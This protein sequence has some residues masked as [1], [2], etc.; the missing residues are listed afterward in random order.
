MPSID[1]VV[2]NIVCKFKKT[3]DIF[4]GEG[5]AFDGL[6]NV[7]GAKNSSDGDYLWMDVCLSHE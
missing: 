4:L 6:G 7:F 5:G 1:G 2:L 3:E